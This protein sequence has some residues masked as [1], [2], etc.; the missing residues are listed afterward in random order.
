MA[1]DIS[2]KEFI[3]RGLAFPLQFDARG[4]LSLTNSETEIAQAIAII[5]STSPGERLMR[6]EFG[7]RIHELVFA[8][9]NATTRGLSRLY[10]NQALARW[11]PRIDV[12][13]IVINNDPGRMGAL[14]IEIKYR[15]KDSYAERSIVYPFYLTGEEE[16]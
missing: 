16:A 13:D 2:D 3:G 8:P 6:P 10:I 1:N 7:C 11:E 4:G 15:V 14:M 9:D 12:I 5:V